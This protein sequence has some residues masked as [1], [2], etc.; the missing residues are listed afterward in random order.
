M[1]AFLGGFGGASE[2]LRISLRIAAA[3]VRM[4]AAWECR[5]G[6]VSLRHPLSVGAA[7][8]SGIPVAHLVP[9]HALDARRAKRASV[10]ARALD[11]RCIDSG[12]RQRCL[13]QKLQSARLPGRHRGRGGAHWMR[14][15]IASGLLLGELTPIAHP[16][17]RS[18]SLLGI[19][20]VTATRT[21]ATINSVPNESGAITTMA[22]VVER[23]GVGTRMVPRLGRKPDRNYD[24]A[25]SS[26]Q[27]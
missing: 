11:S 16:R 15:S 18:Q 26:T 9:L 27:G 17:S 7:R 6:L 12:L 24:C 2:E 23:S 20:A 22:A 13:E 21:N 14:S 1:P 4:A 10:Y 5:G 8:V 3:V 19:A 25:T